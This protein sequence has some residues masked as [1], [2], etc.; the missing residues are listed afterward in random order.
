MPGGYGQ[1]HSFL[2]KNTKSEL[3]YVDQNISQEDLLSIFNQI[4]NSMKDG[5]DLFSEKDLFSFLEE[6]MK[7]NTKDVLKES[8]ELVNENLTNLEV[9][10]FIS[11]SSR[12]EPNEYTSLDEEVIHGD[13]DFDVNDLINN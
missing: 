11:L 8:E 9:E 4:A 2:V 7:E 6:L 1:M 10:D 3:N 12:L 13:R 5:T